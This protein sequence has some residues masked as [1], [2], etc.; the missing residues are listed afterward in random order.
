[1]RLWGETWIV[2]QTLSPSGVMLRCVS[3]TRRFTGSLSGF[4]SA[5]ARRRAASAAMSIAC[6]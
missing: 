1:M 5:S 2:Y 4:A 6:R 3:S